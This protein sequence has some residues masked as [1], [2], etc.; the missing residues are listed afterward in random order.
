MIQHPESPCRS[1]TILNKSKVPDIDR[2][3]PVVTCSLGFNLRDH[4]SYEKQLNPNLRISRSSAGSSNPYR[5]PRP[6]ISITTAFKATSSNNRWPPFCVDT[7]SDG[8][9][10]RIETTNQ[11]LAPGGM[12]CGLQDR[13]GP[14]EGEVLEHGPENRIAEDMGTA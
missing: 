12:R 9:E 13:G 7:C 5:V 6:V 4:G 3:A 1:E 11:M 14:L 10:R 2:I 8:E